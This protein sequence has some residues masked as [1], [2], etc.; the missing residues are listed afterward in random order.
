MEK[1]TIIKPFLSFARN[2]ISVIGEYTVRPR[3]IQRKQLRNML[4]NP[5]LNWEGLQGI[6]SL[7]LA[8]NGNYFARIL[9]KELVAKKIKQDNKRKVFALW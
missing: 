8:N 6:S 7:M 1:D 3:F 5:Y 9:E 4:V 2:S